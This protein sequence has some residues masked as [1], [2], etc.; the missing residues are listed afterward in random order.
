V[1]AWDKFLSTWMDRRNDKVY[2]VASITY[3]EVVNK[4][5]W[6][7]SAIAPRACSGSLIGGAKAWLIN[8]W[9]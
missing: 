6:T 9:D 7:E 2:N 5:F 4:D 3:L 1:N 8:G